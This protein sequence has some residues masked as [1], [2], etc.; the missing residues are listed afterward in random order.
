MVLTFNHG[1]IDY[2]LSFLNS[3]IIV[4]L[5]GNQIMITLIVALLFAT[6][7]ACGHKYGIITLFLPLEAKG[8]KDLHD[9]SY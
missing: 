2:G 5:Y 9:N 8:S 3:Q 1:M 4:N 7:C 6:F